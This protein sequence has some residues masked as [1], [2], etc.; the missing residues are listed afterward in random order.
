MINFTFSE[1]VKQNNLLKE[2]LGSDS[3]LNISVLTNLTINQIAPY[4]EFELRDKLINAYCKIGEYDNIV[5][6]SRGNSKSNVIVIF[7]EAANI[8]DG[9]QYKINN[10]SKEELNTLIENTKS[11]IKFVLNNLSYTPLIIFNEFSSLA[12]NYSNLSFN[13]FDQL[14]KEL[15]DF[16]VA[17]SEVRNNLKTINLENILVQLGVNNSID[18][19]NYYNSKSLYTTEFLKHY[20]NRISKFILA[21]SGKSKK[22][23]ILDCDNTLWSGIVGEDGINGLKMNSQDYKGVVFE[24][25]QYLVK[26][27]L[28]EGVLLGISSK[29]NEFDVENVFDNHDSM[30]LKSNDFVIKKIN[31]KSK[32]ENINEMAKELNL[33]LDSFVFIDDSDFEIDS[34]SNFLPD[35]TTMQVPKLLY[36]YPIELKRCL[37]FFTKL[38]ISKEDFKRSAMYLD[39]Q[40]RSIAKQKFES[41][42]EYLSS[43]NL[44][45]KICINNE[46]FIP[47]ISQ[48]TQKTNQ[49][50]LTTKRYSESEI[51]NILKSEGNYIFSLEVKD[52]F[53]DF[54][55]TG[56]CIIECKNS[57][58]VINAFLLSCR[59]LGRNIEFEFINQILSFLS[60][61]GLRNVSAKYIETYKNSQVSDFYEKSGFE[62]VQENTKEKFYNINLDS[63]S[64]FKMNH[65]K[66]SNE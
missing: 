34:V 63:F 56:I 11:D 9:L 18:F 16:L 41:I 43:L 39:E 3:I 26:N 45:I 30:I 40:N 36:Q 13:K 32:V 17:E 27:L 23:L 66:I 52:R 20:V 50:N 55:V 49:F 62:L 57:T 4:L 12:F 10:Y 42:D 51:A 15:N 65:I 37:N 8:I 21:L 53:G 7:W 22:V 5:Q 47:R 48:L 46:L 61:N 44:E 1:L 54:G 25:V 64:V 31:W 60:K 28:E 35:V 59:I 58:A 33:G 19:R 24:E 29:N 6:D 38:T 2:K 14:C